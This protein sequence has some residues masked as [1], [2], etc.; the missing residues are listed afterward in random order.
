MK[1]LEEMRDRLI[2]K[3]GRAFRI[4]A[5]YYWMKQGIRKRR[6]RKTEEDRAVTF[7]RDLEEMIRI[8]CTWGG[9][10]YGRDI[11]EE[12][13]E[14]PRRRILFVSHELS[15]TGAPVALLGMIRAFRR[16][17]WQPVVIC[18]E[19]GPLGQDAA[20]EGIPVIVIPGLFQTDFTARVRPLFRAVVVNTIESAPAVRQIDGTD[21]PV[22]WWI[23]ESQAV[24]G[25]KNAMLMPRSVSDNV[26]VCC[27]GEYARKL[28]LTRAPR[29]KAELLLY[30]SQDLAAHPESTSSPREKGMGSGDVYLSIGTI[31]ERKGQDVLLDAIELLPEKVLSGTRFAFAGKTEDPALGQRILSKSRKDPD[32][33]ICLG[34]RKREEM[35]GIYGDCR[36]LVCSSRDDPMPMVIAEAMSLGIPCICS[37]GTGSA[38]IIRDQDA[39]MV[40][41]GDDPG[42]LAKKI[43]E[44]FEISEER[45]GEL[46]ANA[47]Q[48]YES[49]F[50]EE[51]FEKRID[52]IIERITAN[53]MSDR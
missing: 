23:H 36:W 16:R 10:F 37:S 46:S 2:E 14:D 43:A 32:R 4:Y 35:A 15:L 7:A 27:V 38:P 51:A 20:D 34:E 19:D 13:G 25:R 12:M 11:L 31:G 26:H 40:Y 28:L 45:Y 3:N 17:G 44:S 33:I 29:Y 6:G 18:R 9:K 49:I 48:A 47:R 52:R 8:A 53:P 42:E 24:Y 41:D 22:I 1:R 5:D 50:S 21:T 39:G 30:H